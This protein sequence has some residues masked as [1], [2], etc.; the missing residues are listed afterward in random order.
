MRPIVQKILNKDIFAQQRYIPLDRRIFLI[1]LGAFAVSSI[2]FLFAGLLPLIAA[3]TGMTVPQAGYLAFAFSIAYALATPVISALTGAYDR[4]VV[5]CASL[6][7]FVAGTV[8]TATSASMVQLVLAQIVTGMA[9]GQFAASG[10][11]VAVSLA[12]PDRR[13]TA[14]S[15]VVG[16]TTF[17]VAFGAPLGS[18]LAHLAG[19]RTGFGFVGAIAAICL[20][21]LWTLLPKNMPGAR[22]SLAER[23][24]V[25][26]RPGVARVILISFIY[27]C[28]GFVV[29]AYLGPIM[30]DGAGVAPEMLPL[31]LLLY[32]I[33]A[34]SGNFISG[35]ISDRVGPR[36]VVIAAFVSGIVIS[37]LMAAAL[38]LPPALAGPVV[39]ALL[40][41]WGVLGWIFPPAQSSR[42]V[43]RA[44]DVAHLTLSLNVSSVYLGVAF[45]TFAGGRILEFGS[46]PGLLYA[47]GGFCLI[48]LVVLLSEKQAPA[49][50]AAPAR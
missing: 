35:R 8:L 17:A 24:E 10:Q 50:D 25:V 1:G 14:I 32:G 15:M 45:G 42:L 26:R 29:V 36:R 28:G 19:W 38:G 34:I 16:G 23:L 39:M 22:L 47:G 48:A 43:S 37:L 49:A 31:V 27:L 3:D 33:G 5:V 40:F 4:R 18:F 13:A 20:V 41:V 44:P 46:I 9:A 6:A 12:P 30:I 21:S 7:A 2:A 11:A